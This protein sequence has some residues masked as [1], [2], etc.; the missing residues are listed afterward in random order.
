MVQFGCKWF[1]IQISD[2]FVND[3]IDGGLTVGLHEA[4]LNCQIVPMLQ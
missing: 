1:S 4:G 2:G 3:L